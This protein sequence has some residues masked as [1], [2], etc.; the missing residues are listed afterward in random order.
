MMLSVPQMKYLSVHL[1]ASLSALTLLSSLPLATASAAWQR[2][3]GPYGCEVSDLVV[4]PQNPQVLYCT[5]NGGGV[6]R[7]DTGGQAW[8]PVSAG[9]E[10]LRTA[11]SLALDYSNQ[12]TLYVGTWDRGLY[13]TTNGGQSW[14]RIS[15]LD[16]MGGNAWDIVIHPTNPQVLYLGTRTG[17]W[18]SSDGGATWV[19]KL[20]GLIWPK[21]SAL[22]I[23]PVV[24]TTLYAGTTFGTFNHIYKT[25]NSGDAWTILNTGIPDGVF[26]NAIVIDPT[27]HLTLYAGTEQGLY[28]STDGGTT[29]TRSDAGI[30]NGH[31]RG[32]AISPANHNNIYASTWGGLFQTLDGA[33]TWHL[34][35]GGFMNA[36][37]KALAF[38][39]TNPAVAY[40]SVFG[41]LYKTIDSGNSW[42]F[43]NA[44]LPQDVTV[45]NENVI[46][47][48]GNSQNIF[49][50][51]FAGGV[52]AS[53]NGGGSFFAVNDGL[54]SGA[55]N[56]GGGACLVQGQLNLF[57][58][59]DGAGLYKSTDAGS[60]WLPRN[61]GLMNLLILAL[62]INPQ[63][64]NVAYL[65]TGGGAYVTQTG[66]N[67]WLSINNGLPGNPIVR[68]LVI[69]PAAPQ[70]VYA[71][72]E[73]GVY[74]TVNAGGSW[75]SI[76]SNLPTP[77]LWC[78][79]IDPT[80]SS[81]LYAGS[82]F[83]GAFKSVN[84]GASWYPINRGLQDYQ[85]VR[86]VFD[87]VVSPLNP[88]IIYAAVDGTGVFK[89]LD[90]GET[91]A[92]WNDGLDNRAMY[93]LVADPSQP[94]V[95][96]AGTQLGV[97]RATDDYSGVPLD[98][99][100]VSSLLLP[101]VS[102][103]S[104]VPAR[105]RFNLPIAGPARLSVFDVGGRLV[106]RL[107]DTGRLGA[108]SHDAVWDGAD[109]AGEA[110]NSGVFYY[111][112][113]TTNGAASRTTV[114]IR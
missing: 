33:A 38:D 25:T 6:F 109:E 26:I 58:G 20:N 48:P 82:M 98:G 53:T 51:T 30:T 66:G 81:I 15:D 35:S 44:G 68:D 106:R 54:P 74:K 42:V 43:Y 5:I 17:V 110:V 50:G 101:T 31:I 72:V 12:Q 93:A 28:K 86:W 112:L 34:A 57:I 39:P 70:T 1:L 69:D 87:F 97:F 73:G 76:S 90:R 99:N 63:N 7:S 71:A 59:I 18:M 36:F 52:F 84:G 64:P 85:G 60:S 78:I 114:L 8:L 40:A 3:N 108:G 23:D 83:D 79:N 102:N 103:P 75:T 49:V 37:I 105:I 61:N 65:G 11:W 14:L 96:Y 29:W 27:N 32:I 94:S 19:Q 62:A 55:S 47:D 89:S 21:I 113:E 80:N 2:L 10:D 9:N 107:V 22:A 95:L 77:S 13:K 45:A 92:P 88:Q 100:A 16:T 67:I 46:I 56:G 4:L 91:W 111:R 24:P 104:A 41:G